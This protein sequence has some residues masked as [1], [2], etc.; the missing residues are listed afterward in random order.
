MRRF[1][2]ILLLSVF[3]LSGCARL[4]GVQDAELQGADK[5]FKKKQYS[6][7]LEAYNKIAEESAG[8]ERGANALFA[9]ASAQAFY[10]NPQKDYA[11]ALQEFE[12][13]LRLYPNNEKA[14][15]AK[16]WRYFLKMLIELK[17]ENENLATS[18]EQLKRIDIRHE[19][20]RKGN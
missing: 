19:E 14:R 5:F 18:I 11:L 13:F 15:D 10:D 1:F 17:K 16:N 12:E 6:E 4:T 2:I 9:A 3:C 20:R 7:A 8:T